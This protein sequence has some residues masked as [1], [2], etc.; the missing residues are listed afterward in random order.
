MSRARLWAR[1]EALEKRAPQPFVPMVIT[2]T[3]LAPNF[4][5]VTEF[6]GP[7]IDLGVCERWRNQ[8]NGPGITEWFDPP[9]PRSQLPDDPVPAAVEVARAQGFG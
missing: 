9:V 1:L 2:R 5:P 4:D 7:P 6:F 3:V 8:K